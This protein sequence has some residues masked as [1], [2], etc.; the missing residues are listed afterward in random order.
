MSV[1]SSKQIKYYINSQFAGTKSFSYYYSSN[2]GDTNT[3]IGTNRNGTSCYFK[4]KI[5]DIR[6]YNKELTQN[7]IEA[8]YNEGI[9][10]S[11]IAVTDTLIINMNANSYFPVAYKNT[12]IVFPNPKN[13]II[14]IDCG[15]NYNSLNNN[16]IQITNSLGRVLFNQPISQQLFT[17]NLSQW[18]GNGLYLLYIYD[19]QNNI[20]DVRKIILQ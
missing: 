10:I 13:S 6:I 4:G 16:R 20:I 11:H 12:I 8:I 7:E 18:T 3:F 14:N 15:Q 9:C 2:D 19:S 1:N 5:D 17:L